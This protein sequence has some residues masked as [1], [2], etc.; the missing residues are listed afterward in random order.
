ML[1]GI[2]SPQGQVG[3][4]PG[5]LE[6]VPVCYGRLHFHPEGIQSRALAQSRQHLG[7]K[8]G[9]SGWLGERRK[10]LPQGAAMVPCNVELFTLFELLVALEHQAFMGDDELTQ[11]PKRKWEATVAKHVG[12]QISLLT[13]SELLWQLF[14]VFG[15][16]ITLTALHCK[17][18]QIH[19]TSEQLREHFKGN[20]EFCSKLLIQGGH[21][22]NYT[23]SLQNQRGKKQ[24]NWQ[25]ALVELAMAMM[26]S[27]KLDAFYLQSIV[28]LA[29]NGLQAL[30]FSNTTTPTV[31]C[32]LFAAH[33]S[34]ILEVV[35]LTFIVTDFC[36]GCLARCLWFAIFVVL[37][38][39]RSL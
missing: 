9:W 20:A 8:G 32:P 16:V 21:L 34:T 39:I 30:N 12:Q 37:P 26:V 7:S 23:L 18:C 3:V 13:L 5:D 10:T 17:A 24:L 14:P 27:L 36:Q 19:W 11:M 33:A 15:S 29:K 38:E 35:L 25:A 22:K 2:L 28:I 6:E 4:R 31:H 1:Q